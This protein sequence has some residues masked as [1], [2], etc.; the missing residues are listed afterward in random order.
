M[1]AAAPTKQTRSFPRSDWCGRPGDTVAGDRLRLGEGEA[2]L[3]AGELERDF[4]LSSESPS[5]ITRP[6]FME[7]D[8]SL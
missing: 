8:R 4:R 3:L 1:P 7:N 5:L 2:L 6:F